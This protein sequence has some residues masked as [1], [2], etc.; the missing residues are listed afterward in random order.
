MAVKPSFI[1]YKKSPFGRNI[2]LADGE[3]PVCSAGRAEAMTLKSD[4]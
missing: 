1:H 3:H 2:F 4:T